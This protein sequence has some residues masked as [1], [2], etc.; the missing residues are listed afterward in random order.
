MDPFF[1]KNT[2]S[3][4]FLPSLIYNTVSLNEKTNLKEIKVRSSSNCS[5]YLTKAVNTAHMTSLVPSFALSV[6]K[7]DSRRDLTCFMAK[8]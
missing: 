1:G 7:S 5:V 6:S 2:L 4:D 8:S 3:Q